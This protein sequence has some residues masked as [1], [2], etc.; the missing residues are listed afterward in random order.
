MQRVTLAGCRFGPR[1]HTNMEIWIGFEWWGTC[2]FPRTRNKKQHTYTTIIY[3]YIY[4]IINLWPH[5]CITSSRLAVVFSL[6]LQ[7]FEHV[8]SRVFYIMSSCQW[9]FW[10][11][12][13]K[14]IRHWKNC[15]NFDWT[16]ILVKCWNFLKFEELGRKIREHHKFRFLFKKRPYF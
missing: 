16:S 12:M 5:H 9:R 6:G 4:S 2:I 8:E 15:S 3:E 1:V 7:F 13:P 14:M 10:L 11:T